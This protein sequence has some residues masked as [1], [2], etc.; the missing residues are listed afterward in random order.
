[1]SITLII[2]REAQYWNRTS[3]RPNLR[4]SCVCHA[5][6][7]G[8]P[9]RTVVFELLEVTP[10]IRKLIQ[11]QEPVQTTDEQGHR[12]GKQGLLQPARVLISRAGTDLEGIQPAHFLGRFPGRRTPVSD[13]A[14]WQNVHPYKMVPQWKRSCS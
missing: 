6:I 9:D 14:E 1:V 13:N 10:S 2:E 4:Q 12:D 8:L 5:I 11:A 3:K 7:R